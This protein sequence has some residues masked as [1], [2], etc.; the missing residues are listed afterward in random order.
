MTG[1]AFRRGIEAF[2]IAAA[3]RALAPDVTFSSPVMVHPYQG[4][5]TVARLL[6]VLTELFEDM[7]Y[8]NELVGEARDGV[9]L[10][11]R[12][13][14]TQALIFEAKIDGKRLQGLDLL[15]YGEDGLVSDLTVMVR[16]LPAAMVLARR[17]G[18][19]MEEL[20]ASSD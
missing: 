19:R 10:P 8:T 9:P 12:A 18:A 15:T 17:V 14:R 11:D 16:P 20:A 6:G 2:D 4:R 5:E 13:N 7:R 3:A 1:G